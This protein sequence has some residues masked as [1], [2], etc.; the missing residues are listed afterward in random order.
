VLERTNFRDGFQ[1]LAKPEKRDHHGGVPTKTPP[2]NVRS[3]SH[4]RAHRE[5]LKEKLAALELENESLQEE[6]C[7]W[8]LAH[9]SDQE[10]KQK[11]IHK[12]ELELAE[13]KEALGDAL[14]QLA[15]LRKQVFGTKS[16][17]GISEESIPEPNQENEEAEPETMLGRTENEPRKRGQQRGAKGHGRKNRDGSLNTLEETVEI[18][19]LCCERCTTPFKA[20]K[21][22]DD[23]RLVQHAVDIWLEVWH[24]LRYVPQCDCDGN[25]IVTAPAPP[26]LFPRTGFGNSMW[27]HLVIQKFLFQIPTHK[28]LQDLAMK[29]LQVSQGTVTGG[30]QKIDGLIDG[31]YEQVLN[32]CRAADLWNGDETSWRVFEDGEGLKKWWLWLI[33][34]SDAAVFVMD[35]TRSSEVPQRFFTASAGILLTDRYSAYKALK[36]CIR[37][38]YCWVHVRRDFVS[39][40]DGR[41]ESRDWARSWIRWI[42][43]LFDAN[44]DR[45]DVLMNRGSSKEMIA[46]AQMQVEELVEELRKRWEAELCDQK[47]LKDHQLKALKSLKKHWEGLTVFVDEARV[48]MD[49]NRAERLLRGPVVGRKNYLASGSEWSGHFAA[50]MFSLLQTWHMNDLDPHALLL[51]YFDE[52]S[53]TPGKPPPDLSPFLPWSMTAERKLLFRLKK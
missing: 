26:R 37:K 2:T 47:S 4:A 39:I 23:T 22:T 40:L 11:Q 30:F 53:K 15:W 20:L 43:D 48:P 21:Q 52:C 12:L 45:L 46:A 7:R 28:T 16:E 49:N 14:Q 19:G 51:D 32:H 27:M 33:S 18:P 25:K 35:K 13:T 36:N 8:R 24:R 42:D 10:F 17:Q 5:G 41:P 9:L 38:A 1:R 34:S 31:L 50:K 6:A 44:R 3:L 29:G